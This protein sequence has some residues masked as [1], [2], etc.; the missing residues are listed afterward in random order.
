MEEKSEVQ[1]AE[2]SV[3]RIFN[4]FGILFIVPVRHF[5]ASD[6]Q[7]PSS[8]SE[9]KYKGECLPVEL[10]RISMKPRGPTDASAPLDSDGLKLIATQRCRSIEFNEWLSSNNVSEVFSSLLRPTLSKS[11]ACI[12]FRK[13]WLARLI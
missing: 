11:F 7:K 9:H 4:P 2:T 13:L 8:I 3:A 5:L 10:I 12:L 1:I 6:S